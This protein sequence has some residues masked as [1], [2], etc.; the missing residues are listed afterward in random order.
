[1]GYACM[2]SVIDDYSRVVYSEIHDDEKATPPSAC[3]S[4]RCHW[5]SARGVRVERVLSDNGAAYRSKAWQ[6]VCRQLWGLVPCCW[7]RG[8]V[9]AAVASVVVEICFS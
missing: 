8:L 6:A 2:H 4:A 1:M 7:T 9:Y 3:S 5:F